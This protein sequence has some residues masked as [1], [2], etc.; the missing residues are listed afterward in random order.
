MRILQ[1]NLNHCEAA[2]DLL[3][4]TIRELDIDVAILCEQYRD[5]KGA[6]W[7]SDAPSRAAIWMCGKYE[8]QETARVPSSGFT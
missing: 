1:L 6:T 4:Q 5:Y 2:Q 3:S 7:A 8:V